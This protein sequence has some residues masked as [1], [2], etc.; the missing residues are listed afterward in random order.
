[1]LQ[2]K[3]LNVVQRLKEV[4]INRER[5]YPSQ[6]QAVFVFSGPGTYYE[7]L[8][9]GQEKHWRW[10]DR[11]RIRAG[12][13]VIREATASRVRELGIDPY[14]KGHY[15]THEEIIEHGPLF[16]YN[17][18]PVEND[19]FRTALESPFS[20]IPKEK[21][22][23]IDEVLEDDGYSHPIRHTGDQVKSL[24]QQISNPNS[25]LHGTEHV[26]LIAHI[27]DFIR[28]V[29]YTK[30]YNDE[31][32]AAG[33]KGVQFWVYALQSRPGTEDE[34][35]SSELPRLVTYAQRG[36]LAR[37]PSEFSV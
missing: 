16:V 10:M 4:A 21:V 11:D 28:D 25:P 37:E 26:A 12:V 13:A 6:I 3:A 2:E 30:K 9:P 20:K 36:D 1:M 24:Y 27:P 14:K 34:H 31:H 15:T 29:F 18:V 23:I 33:S 22:V 19:V 32:M 7:R 8:K 17:G 5:T 35:I